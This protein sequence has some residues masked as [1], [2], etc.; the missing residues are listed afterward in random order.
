MTSTF[1]SRTPATSRDSLLPGTRWSTSTPSH[2]AGAGAEL[3]DPVGEHV[4]AVER[5]HDD[6]FDAQV[7]APD[8]FDQLG[9]VLALD[10][11][12]RVAGDARLQALDLDR[13]GRRHLLDRRLHRLDRHERHRLA[14]QQE[15]GGLERE[16]AVAA[17]A[18]FEHDVAVLDLDHGT[19]EPAGRVFDDQAGLGGDFRHLLAAPR[20]STSS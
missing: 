15:P 11:D 9:V 19:A 3:G 14:L 20:S 2:A 4:D 5:F 18:V 12:P 1:S 7:V 16:H 13:T 6:A 8:A 10:P 17:L